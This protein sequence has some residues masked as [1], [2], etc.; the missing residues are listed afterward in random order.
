MGLWAASLVSTGAQLILVAL[1]DA[2]RSSGISHNHNATS[3][4]RSEGCSL[5]AALAVQ[6]HGCR[7][8]GCAHMAELPSS[9][10][11]RQRLVF[12]RAPTGSHRSGYGASTTP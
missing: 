9:R 7:Q 11:Q 4:N 2:R 6:V 1:C 10:D 5:Q 12:G 3:N 8:P